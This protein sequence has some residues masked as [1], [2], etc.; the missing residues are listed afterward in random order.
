MNSSGIQKIACAIVF[1]WAGLYPAIS[2]SQISS[3]SYFDQRLLAT[4]DLPRTEA[5]FPEYIKLLKVVA[6]AN[7]I[8]QKTI[9]EAFADVYFLHHVIV[10]DKNQPERQLDLDQYLNRISA[11]DRIALAKE[12]YR[13]YRPAIEKATQLTGVEPEYILALWGVESRYGANQGKEDVISALSTLSF[14]GRRARFFTNE[15][16]AALKILER[17]DISKAKFKGSWAGA[18]GQTQFMPTSLLAYGMDGDGDGKVDIWNNPYDVLASIGNYLAVI[19]W[20]NPAYWGNKVSVP[21]A[22]DP[23]LVGLGAEKSKS[24]LAWQKQGIHVIDNKKLPPLQTTA[25]LILPYES[26][27]VGYLV[28]PNF[29]TIMHWN[30]SYHFAISV[31]S[32]ADKLKEQ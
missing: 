28:Y 15:L 9:D 18:M 27:T 4:F 12:K 3:P 29:S 22:L 32:I 14:E 11:P 30:H 16:L 21:K 19:G 8:T 1:I 20:K 25:W 31:G 17:G 24:L 23:Q 5:N 13:E 26:K 7:G 2:M 10:A 6:S